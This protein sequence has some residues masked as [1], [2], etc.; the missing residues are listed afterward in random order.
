[1]HGARE[2]GDAKGTV[3]RD[4]DVEWQGAAASTPDPGTDNRTT[5]CNVH[6]PWPPSNTGSR[7]NCKSAWG[8]FDMVGNVDEWVADWADLSPNCTDWTTSAGISGSDVSCFGG[9]GGAGR[10]SVP[11]ALFRGGDLYFGT[12]A[13]VFAVSATNDPSF[14]TVTIGFRCAR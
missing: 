9:P 1:V 5:D 13:G 6:T 12:A 11:G 4:G 10:N 2:D 8:V 14:S 7:S 3:F